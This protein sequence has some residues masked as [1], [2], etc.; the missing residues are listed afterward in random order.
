MVLQIGIGFGLGLDGALRNFGLL[1]IVNARTPF[2]CKL[3]LVLRVETLS[4][5]GLVGVCACRTGAVSWRFY[6]LPDLLIIVIEVVAH[7]AFSHA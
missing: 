5:F 4:E 1:I 3:R 6:G 7:R 2:L